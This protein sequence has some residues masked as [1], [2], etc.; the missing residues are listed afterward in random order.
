MTLIFAAV[1]GDGVMDGVRGLGLGVGV[2]LCCEC[3]AAATPLDAVVLVVVVGTLL[4]VDAVV[5]VVVVRTIVERAVS[6]SI[7][8]AALGPRYR[9]SLRPA[10][11]C[12]RCL[13]TNALLEASTISAAYRIPRNRLEEASM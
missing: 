5:L 6:V 13:F 11:V 2:G 12:R 1:P 10:L 8:V 4:L 3:G 9:Q 7:A